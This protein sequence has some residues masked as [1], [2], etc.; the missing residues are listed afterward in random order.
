MRR[1]LFEKD[2]QVPGASNV[3]QSRGGAMR[4][5]LLP[6]ATALAFAVAILAP[7]QPD[8]ATLKTLHN[9]CAEADCTDGANPAAGLMADAKGNLYGTTVGGGAYLE[10]TVFEIAKTG[11][12]GYASTPTI[13]VSFDGNDGKYPYGGLVADAQGDLFGTTAGGGA[14]NDGT[15]FE[16]AKIG[17]NHYSDAPITL[18]SFDNAGNGAYPHAGLAIDSDGN[19]FGTT[20]EGGA[21][22][23]GTVFEIAKTAAGYAGTPIVLYSFCVQNLCTDGS[24]PYASLAID[25]AGNLFG[26][27]YYGGAF[28]GPPGWGTVF[29]IVKT[30]SGYAGTPTT[31]VS[32]DFTDGANPQAG[33][34]LDAQGDLFG[35][36]FQGA[37]GHVG[38]LPTCGAVFEVAKSAGVYA[39]SPTMLVGFEGTD[40]YAPVAGLVMDKSGN[41]YG[42]TQRGRTAVRGAKDAG[43][44][45]EIHKIGANSYASAPAVMAAF[46]GTDGEYPYAGLI[47]NAKGKLFGTTYT[48]G[49]NGLGTVFE[50]AKP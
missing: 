28:G 46:D 8:A 36:T 10:G 15:V 22:G 19:L 49:A 44:V 29:E 20:T 11:T 40:G 24:Q 5:M 21:F 25:A 3:A 35:T 7:G 33:L 47:L 4:S 34:V 9:F 43:T 31:L 41:L 16:I 27:T 39:T 45:F 12:G 38:C 30:A 2:R 48:G 18:A 6:S 14:T 37:T 32:F 50:V 1:S 17:H 23:A 13:L 26:T 42:T